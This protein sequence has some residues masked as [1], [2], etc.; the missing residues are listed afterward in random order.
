MEM[1]YKKN[2]LYQILLFKN[3][4]QTKHFF[5]F[6]MNSKYQLFVELTRN[7][8]NSFHFNSSLKT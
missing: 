3:E 7:N 6:S 5:H 1:F 4:T 2:S 8:K